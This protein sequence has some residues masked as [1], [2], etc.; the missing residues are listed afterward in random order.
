M[1]TYNKRQVFL[2]A[3]F[4]AVLAAIVYQPALQNGFLQWD[5][6]PHIL[7]NPSIQKLDAHHVQTIFQSTIHK[8]YIPLTI[9]SFAI[10]KHFFGLDPKIFHMTNIFLHA[11]VVAAIFLLGLRMG[12]GLIAAFLSA[13]LFGIHPMHVESVA[14]VTERKDVLYAFFYLLALYAY[15]AYLESSKR[16]NYWLSVVIGFFSM[17]A[18]P[19]ALSL[20]LIL[21]LFDW[22]KRR[23]LTW[24]LCWN[25]IPFLT[26]I[27]PIAWITYLPN[28][29]IPGNNFIEAILIWVWTFTF[30]I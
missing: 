6:L 25:K 8:T 18:K 23:K 20:P 3:I 30:F 27:I 22:F 21:F 13:V 24:G 9:L 19:M 7:E 12:L 10:E 29:R 15:W 11:G 28:A 17:L 14:W 5:D 1:I 16:H 26:Y 2:W 4:A